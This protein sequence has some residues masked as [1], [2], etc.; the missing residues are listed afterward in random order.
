MKQKNENPLLSLLFNLAIPM[1]I[2]N[3]LTDRMG[4]QNA[5]ILALAF[6]IGYSLFL[7]FQTRKVSS[8]AILGLLNILVTGGFALTGLTGIW[9]AIKEASFPALVGLFVLGSAYSKKP[10]IES[11]LLNPQIMQVQKLETHLKAHHKGKLFHELLQRGTKLLS[12]SFLFS[13]IINFVLAVAIFKP[14]DSALGESERASILNSQIAEMT[15]WSFVAIALPSM[16]F[17]GF[18]LYYLLKKIES[19]TGEP[20]QSFLADS[21]K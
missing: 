17:M 2:L 20:F 12:L 11:L 21:H 3:K 15:G 14:L 18:L 10:F 4:P 7:F 9:F 6:P 5:L 16:I 13:A 19:L 1:G 8:I